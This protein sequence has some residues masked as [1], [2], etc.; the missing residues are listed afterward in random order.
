MK[1]P[2]CCVVDTNVPIAANRQHK[3]DGT[4]VENEKWILACVEAIEHVIAEHC[5]VLD[6]AD[7]ILGEY[8]VH[9]SRSGQ[10]GVGDHFVKW[11]HDCREQFPDSN[12]RV[13]ITKIGDS[14]EEF[15]SHAGLED[16]DISDRKFV[17]VSN[18][19][20][21]KP[22]IL[23]A[24]DSKW[25]GWKKALYEVGIRVV[26]LCPEYTKEKYDKKIVQSSGQRKR[27]AAR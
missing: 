9:L 24:T 26:F 12:R 21:D 25:V 1:L 19:H 11:I 4:E 8:C 13:K 20:P 23:Q 14:Y 5:L 7:E 10:P 16:F 15:P 18:A 22:P 6:E 17:A 3:F 2:R 27:D